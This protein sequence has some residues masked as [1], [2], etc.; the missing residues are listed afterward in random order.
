VQLPTPKAGGQTKKSMVATIAAKN[1]TQ[2][3]NANKKIQR[4]E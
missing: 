3:K 1:V 2:H 4:M